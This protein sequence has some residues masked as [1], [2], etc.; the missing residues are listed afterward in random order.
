M[1]SAFTAAGSDLVT[2]AS[3]VG[4]LGLSVCYDLRFPELYRALSADPQ[5]N[6]GAGGG[7]KVLAIPA[8]FTAPT[9]VAHWTAL[10]R[11]RAMY[12]VPHSRLFLCVV[13][14]MLRVV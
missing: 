4:T 10:L 12:A 11:A 8:A 7:A 9:G 13:R 5:H 6:G 3:P 14:C 2:C 1:Q